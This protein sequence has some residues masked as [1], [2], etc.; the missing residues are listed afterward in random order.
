[1][2]VYVF[3]YLILLDCRAIWSEVSVLNVLYK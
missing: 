1:L 3:Y 2:S